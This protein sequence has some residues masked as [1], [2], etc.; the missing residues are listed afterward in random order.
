[1]RRAGQV[2][3]ALGLLGAVLFAVGTANPPTPRPITTDGL[4]PD[5]GELVSDY[6]SRGRE[7]LAVLDDSGLHWGLVSFDRAVGVERIQAVADTARVSQVVF[8]VPIDRVQTPAVPVAVGAS[9]AA[10]ARAGA[11]AAGRL[12]QTAPPDGRAAEIARITSE[13]LAAGCECVVAALVRADAETLHALAREPDVRVV[14]ALGTDSPYGQ[15]AVRPLLP[16]YVDVV[17]PG[18]DDGPVPE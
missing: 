14:E 11:L 1:M 16:E 4:G 6:A 9:D 17:R 10:L 7:S 3:L 15:F 8:Q 2:I 12:P 13:R 18:P 5:S